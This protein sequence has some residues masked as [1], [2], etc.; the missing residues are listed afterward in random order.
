L[1]MTPE[2]RRRPIGYYAIRNDQGLQQLLV[3][4]E[5]NRA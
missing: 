5:T 4:T 1:Q 3:G 2:I